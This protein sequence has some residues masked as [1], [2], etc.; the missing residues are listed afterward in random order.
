MFT[1][2]IGAVAQRETAVHPRVFRPGWPRSRVQ[3]LLMGT[4][5]DA[6]QGHATGLEKICP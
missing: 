5:A 6:E 3:E 1:K 4:Y 2:L